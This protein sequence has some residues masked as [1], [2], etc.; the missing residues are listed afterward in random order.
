MDGHVAAADGSPSRSGREHL[1]PWRYSRGNRDRGGRSAR[2]RGRGGHGCRTRP[3]DPAIRRG[4]P[5]RRPRSATRAGAGR[6]PPPRPAG[7]DDRGGAGPESL[8]VELDPLAGDSEAV[9]PAGRAS[10]RGSPGAAGPTAG[11]IPSRS[12][13]AGRTSKTWRELTGLAP[14]EVVARHAADELASCSAGSLQGSH[15]SANWRPSCGSRGWPLRAPG[16]RPVPLPSRARSAPSIPPT[17]PAAGAVIGR[18][19]S[20]SSI[21]TARG[22]RSWSP[23][24]G[25]DSSRH[26][27][28]PRAGCADIGP[29]RQRAA[30][31]APP[32]RACRWGGRGGSARLANRLVGNAE[33][34]S[35]AR[36]HARG[37]TLRFHAAT[38]VAVTGAR[39]DATVDGLPLP[40][41]VGRPARDGSLLRI[42]AGDGA[43]ALSRDRRRDRRSARARVGGDRSAQRVRW[44]S[45]AGA[46]DR[47]S[48]GPR[49]AIRHRPPLVGPPAAGPI[50]IVAGRTPTS[51]GWM[52]W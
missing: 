39:F 4:R 32:R 31:M 19:R 49:N 40:P 42:G 15:T 24:T 52:R 21:R 20:C 29:D 43:R 41:F 26:D 47:R 33:G 36:T 7:R 51:W 5:A 8:L 50:R 30:R 37:P 22:R 6:L 10:P 46:A 28:G 17:C 23:A 3:R 34:R 11:C 27:R 45:G 25:S 12:P 35:A 2:A 14:S 16:R 18:A 9:G 48:P 44:A 13:T 1:L 38:A